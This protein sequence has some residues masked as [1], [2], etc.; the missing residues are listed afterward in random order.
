MFSVSFW[1]EFTVWHSLGVI[2]GVDVC[3]S[4]QVCVSA[5]VLMPTCVYWGCVMWVHMYRGGRRQKCCFKGTIHVGFFGLP[6]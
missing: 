5:C 6:K 1:V 4:L 3:V 2:A